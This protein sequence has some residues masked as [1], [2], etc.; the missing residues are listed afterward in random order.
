MIASYNILLIV[1]LLYALKIWSKLS[2]TLSV[3]IERLHI[4]KQ[5]GFSFVIAVITDSLMF[6]SKHVIK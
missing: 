2:A 4:T 3:A 1:S 5:Y 6:L